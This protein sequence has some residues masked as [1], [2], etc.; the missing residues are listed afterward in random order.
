MQHY[1]RL[2]M[3]LVFAGSTLSFCQDTPVTQAGTDKQSAATVSVAPQAGSPDQPTNLTPEME[4]EL[5]KQM[6]EYLQHLLDKIDEILRKADSGVLEQAFQLATSGQVKTLINKDV[7]LKHVFDLRGFIDYLRK[8]AM[9]PDPT[10]IRVLIVILN[11]LADNL[12][13]F[14]SSN[15]NTAQMPDF[16]TAIN[17]FIARGDQQFDPEKVEQALVIVTKKID[18][19]CINTTNLGLTR[20]NKAYRRFEKFWGDWHMTRNVAVG[21]LGAFLGYMVLSKLE[22][23]QLISTP[24]IGKT[25]IGVKNFAPFGTPIIGQ[26]ARYAVSPIGME[27][28]AEATGI[29]TRWQDIVENTFHLADFKAEAIKVWPLFIATAIATNVHAIKDWASFKLDNIGRFLRGEKM[30]EQLGGMTVNTTSKATFADVIGKEELKKTFSEVIEYLVDPL[31][32]SRIGIKLPN[33]LLCG[34]TRAGKSF[35]IEAVKNEA[36]ARFDQMG[37]KKKVQLYCVDAAFVRRF[38]GGLAEILY[39]IKHENCPAILFIDEIDMMDWQRDKDSSGLCK[40]LVALSGI[41]EMENSET[42]LVIIGATNLPENI[43]GALLQQ[44]RFGKQIWFDYPQENERFVFL[45]RELTKRGAMSIS[46][47]YVEKLARETDGRSFEDLRTIISSAMQK[48]KVRMESLSEI[49]IETALDEELRKITDDTGITLSTEQANIVASHLAAQAL[50]LSILNPENEISKVTIKCYTKE[51]KEQTVFSRMKNSA[52]VSDAIKNREIH[53][54]GALFMTQK[55]NSNTIITNK[56]A[57][58]HIKVLLAGGKG[59]ELITGSN[60]LSYRKHERNEAFEAIR[61]QITNGLDIEKLSKQKQG[62]LN[63][64]AFERMNQ[65]EQEITQLLTANRDALDALTNALKTKLTLTGKEVTQIVHAD[66]RTVNNP[67]AMAMEA[68]TVA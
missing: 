43:D 4:Q 41:N 55:Q 13:G 30:R 10:N 31:R 25:L 56:Q 18:A 17:Q 68:T 14:I 33:Y 3:S 36:Q 9:V 37:T 53:E 21:S 42:P 40:A 2:L 27:R 23:K 5:R 11:T 57:D 8:T 22:D 15:L 50:V 59:E 48:A 35:F 63:D 60:S 51:I 64:Q 1:S 54:F 16:D 52:D 28:T 65:Y 62:A 7:A 29:V 45:V 61:N 24:L 12:D 34:K 46:K 67:A 19:V 47:E 32:F 20:T 66:Y 58:A 38:Q 44:G 26:A 6:H 39:H 49:H